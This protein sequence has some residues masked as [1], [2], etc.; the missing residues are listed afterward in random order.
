MG[1]EDGV[2]TIY[3]HTPLLASIERIKKKKSGK[4]KRKEG[5]DKTIAINNI[6]RERQQ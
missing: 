5:R 1:D 6:I 3:C 4:E 2:M